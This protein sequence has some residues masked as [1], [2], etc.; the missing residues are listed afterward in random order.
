MKLQSN[1]PLQPL[2]PTLPS[3]SSTSN[4]ATDF[5]ALLMQLLGSTPAAAPA[6]LPAAVSEVLQDNDAE[7]QGD[8]DP[9]TTELAMLMA[10]LTPPQLEPMRA[11]GTSETDGAGPVLG[12]T[13]PSPLSMESVVGSAAEQLQE[14]V[15]SADQETTEIP[16]GTD[17]RGQTFSLDPLR[18][19]RLPTAAEPM[20]ARQLH[21]PVGTPQW[22][23][24]LGTQVQWLTERGHQSASLRMSP[25]HLGP[26]EVKITIKDDQASVWF[27]ASNADTRAA[28]ES[29]LPRLREMLAGQGLSLTDAG[30][31]REPPHQQQPA[32]SH[33]QSET[34]SSQSTESA[35]SVKVS[36]NLVDAYA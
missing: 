22:S 1:A 21:A 4:T 19:T 8:E 2:T 31:F 24:E 33:A 25:E 36:V 17:V 28:I 34:D 26:V 18:D 35:T 6:A 3:Q 10:A 11:V 27:G 23:E 29:A 7:A 5:T 9:A 13:A 32:S 12:G 15:G 16:S 30:V 14:L 20:I